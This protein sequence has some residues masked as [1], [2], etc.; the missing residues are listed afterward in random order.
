MEQL[1]A[2]LKPDIDNKELYYTEEC[3]KLLRQ[4]ITIFILT[5]NLTQKF[6]NLSDFFL[7]NKINNDKVKKDLNENIIQELKN[8]GWIIANV[9]NKTGIII[10]NDTEELEK[11]VWKSTLD[12]KIR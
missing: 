4:N 12:F 8:V 7:K 10:C 3:M 1:P 5:E 11:S 9:F 6:Y 2:Y